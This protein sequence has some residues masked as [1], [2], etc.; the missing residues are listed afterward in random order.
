MGVF[1]ADG[2]LNQGAAPSGGGIDWDAAYNQSRALQQSRYSYKQRKDKGFDFFKDGRKTTIEDYSSAF[3]LK[4][5]DIRGYLASEGDEQNIGILNKRFLEK[6]KTIQGFN[7]LDVNAQRKLLTDLQGLA[8]R[9]EFNTQE[10]RKN[11][12]WAQRELDKIAA[13]NQLGVAKEKEGNFGT[14]LADTIGGVDRKTASGASVPGII[15]T[16]Q[17]AINAQGTVLSELTPFS[18]SKTNEMRLENIQRMESIRKG[19]SDKYANGVSTGMSAEDKKLYDA[20]TNRIELERATVQAQTKKLQDVTDPTKYGGAAAQVALDAVTA[21]VGGSLLTQPV[22]QLAG[23]EIAKQVAKNTTSGT[24]IGGGYGASA[25][26]ESLGQDAKLEDYLTGTGVGLAFGGGLGLAGSTLSSA[27]RA[28]ATT[29]A[30]VVTNKQAKDLISYKGA[31]DKGRVAEYKARI[32]AG[33]DLEPITVIK[34]KSG[35]YRIEDGKH[36]YEAYKQAGITNI[37]VIDITPVRKSALQKV[38]EAVSLAGKKVADKFY[39]TTP[40]QRVRQAITTAQTKLQNSTAPIY[41]QLD[42]LQTSGRLTENQVKSVKSLIQTSRFSARTLADDFLR[43]DP[44]ANTLLAPLSGKTL[45]GKTQQNLSDYINA[46]NELNLIDI[47]KKRGVKV[48]P[49]REEAFRRQVAELGTPEFEARFNADVNLNRKLTDLLVEEGLVTPQQRDAWRKNN[50]EYIRVQRLLEGQSEIRGGQGTGARVSR[51]STIASQK[52]KGSTKQAT[53]ALE[54]AVDRTNRVWAEITSNRAANAYIDAL[55]EAGAIGKQ[56]RSAENVAARQDLRDALRFSRPLKNQLQRFEKSQLQYVR[57]IQNE[58]NKL[59]RA[60]LAES[61]ARPIPDENLAG[62]LADPGAKMTRRELQS[63]LDNIVQNTDTRLLA[64]I[65]KQIAKREPKLARAIDELT[66]IQDR[67]KG[68]NAERLNQYNEAAKL[69][70]EKV[71]GRPTIQRFKNGVKEVFETTPEIEAAAKG[72]GPVYMGTLGKI[73]SAPV[74]FLQTTITGGLNPAWAAISI[75]RDFVEGFV[76][77][78]RAAQTHNPANVIASALEAAGIKKTDDDLFRQF[79]AYERGSSSIIDLTKGAKDNARTIRELSRSQMPAF[80]RGVQVIKT[81]RDWYE[82]L[83]NASKWNEFAAK[84]QNFRGNYNK[85][86]NDGMDA[87]Q[88]MNI[89]LYEARNATG[90]LLEKGDWTKALAAVYPYFNP[91]IQGGASLAK[92]F[93]DR[94]VSTSAKIL[95]GI[96]IPAMIATAWNMSD[97]RRAE[98]YL[99]ISPEERERY[100]IMVLPGSE[101]TNGKWQVVKIPKAPG[102]GNFANPIERMM[103]G[104]Y[105][106][107]PGRVE[108]E[109]QSLVK[110]FGSPIDPGSVNQAIGSAI[111]FQLKSLA[112]GAANFDFYSG[113]EI[114]PDW[115]KEQNPNEPYKQAFDNTSATAKKIGQALGISPLIVNNFISDTTGEFG[116][117]AIWLSD[118]GQELTGTGEGV[119]GRSPVES[120][121]RAYSGAYGGERKREASEQLNDIFNRKTSVSSNITEALASRDIDTASRLAS[122]YNDEITALQQFIK[123]NRRTVNLTDKQINALEGNRFPVV[124]GRLSQ[125]SINARLRSL[126][127]K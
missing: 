116:R 86:I 40:G 89:A 94:P 26:A 31:P 60:G 121:T 92:A 22:K 41:R 109:W 93:R 4:D 58:L 2:S 54:T 62:K 29:P 43:N 73:I 42:E 44:D 20:L 63:V 105:G 61:L 46:R 59:N 56:L 106:E 16:Y 79:M 57:R 123:E 64:A 53:D 127:G 28:R 85:L 76:L 77:S 88:A 80:Q 124:D 12:Q 84:Y 108:K 114:V 7:K 66:D 103:I 112:E 98:A 65:R 110:A 10:D 117:N 50:T 91:A 38:D 49:A 47:D 101:Q 39:A 69:A 17:R 122:E 83:Q 87:D 81:P 18:T 96:Q 25:T 119:G 82:T 97:P 19:I 27:A 75:P 14:F 78:R 67:L 45:G 68:I 36:R 70:D 102:V 99:D 35:K 71:R 48:N 15:D 32:E 6:D 13:A 74:R 118:V 9:T 111:P 21:G 23:R 104:M 30:Q 24:F 72:F 37:P 115:L 120:V 125:S 34:D 107:D 51:G 11:Q 1:N 5:T 113:K 126:Q 90:N 100:T 52:R 33:G 3:D 8:G 55:T 95:T